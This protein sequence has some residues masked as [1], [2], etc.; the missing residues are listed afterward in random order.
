MNHEPQ[1]NRILERSLHPHFPSNESRA[2][3]CLQTA[4]IPTR[5]TFH[6]SS[7]TFCCPLEPR[8]FPPTQH[9]RRYSFA[10][11]RS[12]SRRHRSLLCIFV[13][14]TIR[15]LTAEVWTTGN[16]RAFKLGR[17]RSFIYGYDGCGCD[18]S[19][20]NICCC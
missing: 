19:T 6:G 20:R 14:N 17:P 1:N 3:K 4:N 9:R 7:W 11:L 13:E 2:M 18:S 15:A 12:S 5:S 16:P 10:S 8:S